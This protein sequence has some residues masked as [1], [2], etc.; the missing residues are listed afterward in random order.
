MLHF[1][2]ELHILLFL[3]VIALFNTI[4][5][6]Q[7]HH[8]NLGN[9]KTALR[10]CLN[11]WPFLTS[12]IY[13][14]YRNMNQIIIRDLNY[15][16][17]FLCLTIHSNIKEMLILLHFRNKKKSVSWVLFHVI[18]LNAGIIQIEILSRMRQCK[19]PL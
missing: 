13:G 15:L 16:I 9:I 17:C 5:L 1:W 6:T 4:Y 12:Y 7:C 3:A 18:L 8:F 2:L 14:K 10:Y 19:V 11:I